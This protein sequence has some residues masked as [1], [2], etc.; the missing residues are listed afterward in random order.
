MPSDA[1]RSK[2]ASAGSGTACATGTTV[3]CAAVPHWRFQA[4]K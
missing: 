4:A 1:P 3:Y 2:L